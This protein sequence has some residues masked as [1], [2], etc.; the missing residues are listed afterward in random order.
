MDSG[1]SQR[2]LQNST[3]LKRAVL[4]SLAIRRPVATLSLTAVVI[5]LGL[6]FSGRLP[7]SLL[8]E[9]DYPHIRV[10]VNY[11]GVTPEVIEEQVTRILERN[12]SA[13]ENLA[14]L[15]GRA[16]EGR[17]YIEMY[18]EVGTDIDLALQDAARQLERARAE[19]PAGIDPPRLMKMDPSQSPVYE[20][21]FSSPLRSSIELREWIDQRLVPQLLTVPGTGTIEV[22]GG[23]EREIDVVVDPERM[24]FYHLNLSDVTQ[25][26]ALRNVDIA[27]GNL[28][29]AQYDVL[30]RTES[31]Y[32]D[33]RQVAATLIRVPGSEGHIRL[34]D[35]AEVSDSYR[36]QRL[37]ARFNGQDAVQVTIMKQ[38]DANTVEVIDGL[39]RTLA[40]LAESG[41]IMPDIAF[42][43]IR[44]ES[45]FI[46]ASLRSVGTAALIGGLLAMLVIYLFLGSLRKSMVIALTLPVAIIATF[47]LMYAG[48]LTLNVM[49]L[50][51]LALGV[52]L[53]ID[54]ALV[55][56]ENIF[57]HREQLG[58]PAE[59]AS[60]EGSAEVSSAVVAGTMTNLAA[61]LPF[62]LLSGMA[63]LIF[64]ELILTIS[65][66][67]FA[68]LAAALTLVPVL[69]SMGG[70]GESTRSNRLSKGFGRV[71]SRLTEWYRSI[72]PLMIRA[73]L[74]VITIAL[75]LFGGSIWLLRGTGTEFLPA[76]DNGRI[77]MRFVL[78]LGTP[79]EPTN[80]AAMAIEDLVRDMPHVQ[81]QYSTAG[82]YFR[83]GQLSLRGG[84]ID[85]VVQLAPHADRRGYSAERWVSEFSGRLRQS[86]M[87]FTQQR[88][89]GPRLEGLRTSFIDDDIS[90]GVVGE[91]LDELEIIARRVLDR[92]RNLEGMGNVQ[93][94]NEERIPQVIIRL[95]EE[96][97]SDMG[98][99]VG[100]AG[101]AI[102]TAVDG[103]VPTKY[104][105]GG[106]EYNIRV[107][108]P[109]TVTGSVND[110]ANMPM[111]DARGRHIPL[112]AIASF[113]SVLGP[114]H[115]ER[116]N[117]IRIVRVNGTVNLEEATVGQVNQRVRGAL[118]DFDL[119]E[120]YSFVF[121]G[122]AESIAESNR[123]M[124]LAIL[125][126]IFFVFVV[127]AIQYERLG[128]PII[129]LSTL[130]FS[131]TGVAVI[132]WASGTSLSA[133]VLLGI[134]FLVGILVNNAILLVEFAHQRQKEEGMTPEKAVAEAGA[135]RLRPI[136]M[137]S[138]T[139]IFG[140]LPLAIGLGEGAEL[141]QPLA[142]S[143]VG[144]MALGTPITL[145]LLPGIFVTVQ[146]LLAKAG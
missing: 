10:V 65:F 128:S 92:I 69:A 45:F 9:V 140:M 103:F 21:A 28:T 108:L 109:R 86:G 14:E 33:A 110:L 52:G 77:T 55:I 133:P 64:K 117:Q 85:M 2:N 63:A 66:A 78:P 112:G 29:S 19:L 7:V 59:K 93:I 75:L 111:F 39:E 73:R 98:I 48:N 61:V 145:V 4:S 120:G 12:L 6:L 3:A 43:S 50:G 8:P 1:I 80:E 22:V 84:M 71:V 51:G 99:S 134:I 104:V 127:M 90:V 57:R 26:L 79:P 137:T 47:L 115:I 107:R 13:T 94:G 122:A 138:L 135:T 101:Q 30:A 125:L 18:F 113:E 83:G 54:N 62:L 58:K 142:L 87:V 44:D 106:F 25:A 16:S 118:R 20:L 67:I 82:G 136:L 70:R 15:Q 42:E 72:I 23:R 123:S 36:E 31:R 116:L 46:R 76:V 139:T 74:I 41:F 105:S 5:V 132:I 91:D 124:R 37:F 129:I 130:P 119:P 141:L 88:V 27:S 146:R 35:V 89:R 40:E 17:S 114:A 53:L 95:D 32:R 24:R 131:I 97:S 34:S 38:P 68:S 96:R 143:V 60:H 81:T 126:A 121:G 49:S 11:P 56:L 100:E 102:R 144:G